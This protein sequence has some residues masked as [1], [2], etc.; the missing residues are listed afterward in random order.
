[1]E[2]Q[3]ITG[4]NKISQ[5]FCQCFDRKRLIQPIDLKCTKNEINEKT[6]FLPKGN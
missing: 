1:M 6:I 5:I 2:Q 4:R 3:Y